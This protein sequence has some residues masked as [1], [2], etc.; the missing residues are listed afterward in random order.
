MIF[1]KIYAGFLTL[2][3]VLS[4][5]PRPDTRALSFTLTAH[6]E[7]G[8]ILLKW[9]T[10]PDAVR[11]YVYRGPGE[12]QE[13]PIPLTDFAITE[14]YYKDT[15]DLKENQKYCYFVK[16]V[17][18]DNKEFLQSME[19]CA[20]FTCKEEIPEPPEIAEEDCKMVLK[21]QVDNKVFWKNDIP[22]PPMDVAPI[23][24]E[25][26]VNLMARYL[27]DQVKATVGW[28]GTTRTVTI[29]TLDGVVIKMQIGNPVATINGV[30]TPI[31]PNNSQVFPFIE[32]GRTYTGLR[33]ISYNLGAT[34]PRDIEW[35]ALTKT[36]VLTFKDPVC[37]WVC[38]CIRKLPPSSLTN[39]VPQYGFFENCN[40]EKPQY[41]KIPLEMKDRVLGLTFSDY[42]KKY[43]NQEYWCVELRV[44]EYGNIV[45]WRARPDQYPNC[46][47]PRPP[48]DCKW[49]C[50]CI[51]KWT[52]APN[53][54]ISIFFSHDC[55]NSTDI[56]NFIVPTTLKDSNMGIT[57]VEYF[58]KYTDHKYWCVQLCI[59]PNN[60][61]VGWKATPE[62]YPNC[63]EE[64]P[65]ECKW[66]PG[67]I[68]KA[69]QTPGTTLWTVTFAVNCKEDQL[70]DVQM[71]G[72]LADVSLNV[73]L[74]DY[75]RKFPNNKYWCAMFCIDSNRKVMKW[76]AT[77]DRY[78]NCCEEAPLDC[79]WICGCIIKA[80]PSAASNQW[81]I[82][83]SPNCKANDAVDLQLPADLLD[84]NLNISI[85]NYIKKYPDM[86]YWCV[87]L[88]LDQ[89]KKIVKWAATPEK[90][91]RCCDEKPTKFLCACIVRMTIQPDAG[92]FYQ[93]YLKVNCT[94]TDTEAYN[95]VLNF[96]ATQVDENLGYTALEY[97]NS[98]PGDPPKSLC[99]EVEI[100]TTDNSIINWWAF[101]DRNPCCEVTD[102][103]RIIAYIPTQ[104]I[105]GTTFVIS[106]LKGKTV[107][108]GP[109]T[110]E[111]ILDTECSLPCPEILVITPY[112]EKCK[113]SPEKIEVKVP[114]CPE[115]AEVKFDC[116]CNQQ[117]KGGRLRIHMPEKCVEGTIIEVYDVDSGEMV[118]KINRSD[119][120]ESFFDIFCTLPC[121]KV[122]K[123]VPRNEKCK[124]TPESQ[125]V[126]M[127][128]C[129]EIID[130]KFD[131]DCNQTQEGGRIVGYVSTKCIEGT[132]IVI[133]NSE[134]TL[135]WSGVPNAN[136]YFDTDC[137]LK[138]PG[139]YKVAARNERCQFKPEAQEVKVPCCPEKAEVKFDCDCTD[140]TGRI[141]GYIPSKCISGTKV[142]IYSPDGSVAWSGIPN[143]NGFFDTGCKL[144]CPGTYKIVPKNE[145]CKFNPESQEVKVPCCPEKVEVKFDCDCT[146]ANGRILIVLPKD[147]ISGTIVSIYDL[148]GNIVT[149]LQPNREGVFDTGCKLICPLGYRVVPK[150][151]K[152]K[153]YPEYQEVKVPCCPEYVKVDFKCE[154]AEPE[155]KGRITGTVYGD[156]GEN[157]MVVIYDETGKSV[158]YGAT[159]ANG[160]FESSAEGKA[161]VIPCPGTYKIVPTKRGC[162]I[163]PESASVTLSERMCCDNNYVAKVDFKCSCSEPTGRILISLP[164][165]CLKGT[166]VW[167]YEGEIMP[168][169]KPIM[170]LSPNRQGVFDTD[171]KL[172]CEAYYVVRPMNENC[173]F[174]P[175]TEGVKV[176]CCPE[177][178]KLNF[179]CECE[180]PKGRVIAYMPDNC[181]KG[182]K[183]LVYEGDMMPGARPVA[184]LYANNQG[185]FDSD[186]TLKCKTT[187]TLYPQNETC[188]FYPESQSVTL[189]CCPEYGKVNFKCECEDLP[190]SLPSPRKNPVHNKIERS[191]YL[192]NDI[193]LLK[194]I[195]I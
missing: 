195:A 77:P 57:F 143:D 151:D 87:N 175:E 78:P 132:K 157:T 120:I 10:V 194:Y 20:T 89:N 160:Y 173:K 1:K 153:F 6:P 62:K 170:Q 33:F 163:S 154:C 150:N 79:K 51:Q 158:W 27:A 191:F 75:L 73:L 165:N 34:G 104:C 159:N 141:T 15:T 139:V 76:Q 184:T 54:N 156:C 4:L 3:L 55:K 30:N 99:I 22:M 70:V 107:W 36:A 148:K 52:E 146:E 112:N 105:E 49:I 114:C 171:C 95:L 102:K 161:C 130:V 35:Q 53:G 25:N 162:Q 119:W 67:Y 32:N 43:P 145:L 174:Y 14:T 138:C 7:C 50:G 74:A 135:V 167:I 39:N 94:S 113:F 86:K 122:Y 127:P 155:R 5:A 80:G 144:K 177:Y 137:K 46:C 29:T 72:T 13:Y 103:G 189:P 26:R 38:G 187:Y 65:T 91:P 117:P 166:T 147:C 19:A 11:Y 188:K 16:A 126:K 168:G 178:A 90:Y 134:G 56:L 17:N 182:T 64:P 123:I 81:L 125:L 8:Y 45:G 85:E 9:E 66:V 185:A 48:T 101:P 42:M 176:P 31:D 152:C 181:I 129:P 47:K 71:E 84:I 106:D 2:L 28:D 124:F 37:K 140:P 100:N 116:D 18:K 59:G 21:Y 60:K 58:R 169:K 172:K 179:K 110:N 82:A 131:C 149:T 68:T 115:K 180:S 44:D 128:C 88:C 41:T 164:E 190:K 142:V 111:G 61:V 118:R 83:F 108:K 40:S 97:Y 98:V 12:G 23:I 93:V 192:T 186:C 69:V 109:A 24:R 63:C 96:P 133:Y 136:G 193:D 121:P 92:G 183:V